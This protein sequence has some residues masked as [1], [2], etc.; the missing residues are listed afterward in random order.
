M[1]RV[2][3]ADSPAAA[4]LGALRGDIQALTVALDGLADAVA[5]LR[6][7]PGKAVGGVLSQ[8]LH[9]LAARLQPPAA[10]EA[11]T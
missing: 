11:P 3:T 4:K 10:P 6:D 5:T 1:A 7:Q 9:S 2:G 8:I